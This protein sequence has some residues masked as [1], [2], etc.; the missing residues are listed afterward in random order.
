MYCWQDEND[1]VAKLHAKV[2][3]VDRHDVLVSSA[4]LTGHGLVRN[5][6]IGIRAHGKP[7]EDAAAHFDELIRSRTFRPVQWG[8][9]T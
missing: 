9:R 1:A 2:V 7:A 3:I 6:E 5:L 4:N 8:S